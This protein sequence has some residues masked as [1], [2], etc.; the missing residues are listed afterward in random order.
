MADMRDV[1]EYT[2]AAAGSVR[3]TATNMRDAANTMRERVT[4]AVTE[5]SDTATD[6]T[7]RLARQTAEGVQRGA[8]YFRNNGFQQIADD[9]LEYAK[10][11]PTQAMAGAAVVGFVIGR[12]VSRDLR[13]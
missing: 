3:D 5:I 12:L 1:D 13:R 11:N 7:R 2:G 4:E 9:V 10:A 8:D 6:T